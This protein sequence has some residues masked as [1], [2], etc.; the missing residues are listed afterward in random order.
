MSNGLEGVFPK[1]TSLLSAESQRINIIASNL[2]NAGNVS[3][4]E[5]SAYHSKHPVFSEVQQQIA[6]LAGDE[7]PIG[8]VQV[9]DVVQSQTPLEWDYQPD[10]PLADA[11]GRVYMSDVNPIEEMADMIASARQ[12]QAGVE[13]LN[14]TRKLM[15]QAI[16]T[17][18]E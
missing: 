14:T 11:Q 6:G 4:S 18:R 5:D 8:G 1:I 2:S 16:R 15:Q 7:Q 9:T 13:V 12:Y 3:G 10:N 17:I